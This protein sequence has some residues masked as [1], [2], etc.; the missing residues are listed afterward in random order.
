MSTLVIVAAQHT[1][2]SS[3]LQMCVAVQDALQELAYA[4]S[5]LGGGLANGVSNS[6]GRRGAKFTFTQGTGGGGGGG[7]RNNTRRNAAN[8]GKGR[9]V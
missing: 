3:D 2:C 4:S 8:S 5:R 6:S 7:K 9:R 1:N